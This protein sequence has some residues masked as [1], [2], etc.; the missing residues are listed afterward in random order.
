MTKPASPKPVPDP[1][2]THYR[3][4]WVRTLLQTPDERDDRTFVRWLQTSSW[5]ADLRVPVAS[6]PITPD[7]TVAQ[8]AAQTGF[9][10]VTLVEHDGTHETCTWDRYFDLQPPRPHPDAGHMVFETPD[11][12]IETGIHGSYLEVWDRL[13]DSVG[14]TIVLQ[15]DTNDATTTAAPTTLLIAGRYAMLVRPRVAAWP[16]DT[17]LG[18]T[19]AQV[20]QRHPGEAAAL[21]DFE[22]SF[23]PID[24]QRWTITHSTLAEREGANGLLTIQP[25][26]DGA[27]EVHWAGE[28][29]RWRVIEWSEPT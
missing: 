14:R 28:T 8:R 26:P 4:V 22:I 11:R 17:Q 9:C 6:R 21:L 24:G 3:G 18:D 10:G 15:Q 29:R 13:P 20:L 2:P 1:V 19:L 23:G 5:H 16:A 7:A 25:C 27:A 12:V